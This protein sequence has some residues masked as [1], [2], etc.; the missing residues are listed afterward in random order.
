[1]PLR[2]QITRVDQDFMG[3]FCRAIL[4]FI[5]RNLDTKGRDFVKSESFI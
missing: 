1:M 2:Y 4:C 5:H 3:N